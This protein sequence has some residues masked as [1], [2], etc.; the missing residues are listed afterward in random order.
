[1]PNFQPAPSDS[2][3][4]SIPAGTYTI[5]TAH[6]D[7]AFRA[8]AFGLMWVRGHIPVGTGTIEVAD[9][10]LTGQGLL[11]A[12]QIATGLGPRDWHLRSSHY[13]HTAKH[14][15]ITV[16]I[17]S[18]DLAA[19]QASCD[20][21]VRETAAPVQMDLQSVEV[22]DGG[23]HIRAATTVDRTVY[24]MLPPIAGVSR[25]VHLEVTVVA[26]RADSN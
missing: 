3:R 2:S 17:N 11:A 12:D 8:K 21:T 13:L 7:V 6:S 9:G 16:A 1:M 22:V 18:A 10:H 24:P 14:P 19:G 15:T 5:D 4:T 23:L 26:R 20:V 25:R